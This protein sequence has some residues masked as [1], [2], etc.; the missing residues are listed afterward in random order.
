MAFNTKDHVDADV[1]TPDCTDLHLA[2]IAPNRG[3]FNDTKY[4][5]CPILFLLL[6][7]DYR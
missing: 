5:K 7:R 1:S 2:F 3:Q 4:K 6:K